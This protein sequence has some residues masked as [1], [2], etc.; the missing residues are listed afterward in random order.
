MTRRVT[1]TRDLL[2]RAAA[3]SVSLPDMMRRLD[4]PLS[5]GPRAYLRRRLQHYSIDTSHFVEEPLPVRPRMA[6][7]KERLEEAAA[8]AHSIREMLDQMGV[9][10]YDSAYSHIAKRLKHFGIDTSHFS[11]RGTSGECQNVLV[12][13]QDLREAVAASTSLAG[14]LRVL[15][16]PDT[17]TER[18]RLRRSLAAS[19][20][21][22]DHFLG[23]AHMRGRSS[24]ARKTAADILRRLPTGA[25]RTKTAQLRRAL[26]ERGIP[27]VCAACGTGEI[28]QGRRLVLEID[29]LNGDR[30][31]NRLHN[32]RYL[33][34]SCHSQTVTF[35]RRTSSLTVR[36]QSSTRNE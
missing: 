35:A 22:T 30:L 15:G 16:R 1:L 10:L 7:T 21:P 8:Q 14:V 27:H 13:E 23:Q 32:L 20:I 19:G 18:A 25:S 26:D 3:G 4:I 6:F 24:P 5:S 9:A 11:S 31:D 36:T 34:P 2:A 28:W 33:C 12:P 29:H 17:G